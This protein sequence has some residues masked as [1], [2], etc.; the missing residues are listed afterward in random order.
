MGK[1]LTPF[2]IIISS[3]R[4]FILS[5][6][7]VM[8]YGAFPGRMRVRSRVWYLNNSIA[9]MVDG[10]QYRSPTFTLGHRFQCVGVD[11]FYDIIVFPY[12]QSV[13]FGISKAT[14]DRTFQDMPKEL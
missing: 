3:L 6:R 1:I 9:C 14:R 13:L 2:R 4:P 10:G 11:D 8:A 7:F 12:M 5:R